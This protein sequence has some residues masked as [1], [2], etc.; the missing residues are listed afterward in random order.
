MTE[1]NIKTLEEE[2]FKEIIFA[3]AYAV[4]KNKEVL[5]RL[6]VFPVP[7]GDTGINMSLTLGAAVDALKGQN[8]SLKLA[9]MT[10]TIAQATLM[11]GRGCSGT[12]L[13]QWFNGFNKNCENR[14]YLDV[15]SIAQGFEK[16]AEFAYHALENPT[17][18]TILTVM[19][20]SA[21]QAI[22]LAK[23]DNDLIKLLKGTTEKAKESLAKTPD[24]LPV[25]KEAGVVDAG[26]KGFVIM[27]EAILYELQ[28][29][30]K[31]SIVDKLIS[32]K[33][34]KILNLK[35][36]Q[37]INKYCFEC[38]ISSN[39]SNLE[40]I[41]DKIKEYGN[42]LI[43]NKSGE[44]IK[45]HIHTNTPKKILKILSKVGDIKES[46]IDNM[47]KQQKNFSKSIGKKEI[48]IIAVTLGKEMEG[49]LK[50]LGADVVIR[51]K[52][53]MNPSTKNFLKAI[54]K[55]KAK[56]IIIL[57]NDSNVLVVANEVAKL[58]PAVSVIPTKTIQQGIQS[59]SVFETK[60]DLE[61]NIGKM[62]KALTEVKSGFVTYAIEGKIYEKNNIEKN[63]FL[64][65]EEKKLISFGKNL[66][67]VTLNLLEEMTKEPVNAIS[68]FYGKNV[69]SETANS[70]VKL[71]ES[72]WPGI[73]IK[74][75]SSGHPYHFY[76]ISI[77]NS[78]NNHET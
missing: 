42:S 59:L 50:D 29:N 62:N 21:Q 74:L 63:D 40:E 48:G 16:G 3:A 33:Y 32:P 13:S 11:K 31:K 4:E 12:I 35:K 18:G 71:L 24:L 41:K 52:K 36:E 38:V 53:I 76:L 75:R 28:G 77:K 72:K 78:E 34:L 60:L 39:S 22:K 44:L 49:I 17:E 55:T 2:K 5:N 46:K 26:G 8:S 58:V 54:K 68:L 51:G 73:K 43:T 61:S 27:L 37:L 25:L 14:E 19:R 67:E 66:N 20:E 7:D 23:Q 30:H 56:S 70:L 69:V 57:P 1:R 47:K 9:D 45:I 15:T 65:F 64:G 10:K 6:N